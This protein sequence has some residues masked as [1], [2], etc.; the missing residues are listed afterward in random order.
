MKFSTA[1]LLRIALSLLIG[2]IAGWLISEGSYR[3]LKDPGVRDQSREIELV[4]PEGTAARVA[5]G[6]DVLSLPQKMSFVEGD[7][8]IVKNQ[9]TVSHQL[10]PVWVPP[11][12]SGVLL[13][14]AANDY[15]YTCSFQTSKVFG[16][17]VRQNLSMETRIQ[18]ALAVGLPSTV[19]LGLYSFLIWPIKSQKSDEESE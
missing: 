19:I 8:L 10:G 13:V 4:I 11:Q 12:S 16:V 1:I 5:A 14:G 6:E 7:L 2:M 18:G 15:I 17:E 9:D 3:L